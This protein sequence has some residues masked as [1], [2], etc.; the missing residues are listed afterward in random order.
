MNNR[1]IIIFRHGKSDWNASYDE[2]HNRP[3]SKK[4][5]NASKKMGMYLAD[6]KQVP[7][8]VIS[9][10]ATRAK[11]TATLAI[12][13]G[14]WSSHFLI[15]DRIYG[16]SSNFLLELIHLLDNSNKS[17]CF[18]GHEPTCSSFISLCTFHS[19]KFKTG[20]MAKIDYKKSTWNQ[21]KFGEGSL[22]WIK[23]PKEVA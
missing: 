23:A 10:S 18:V 6:I 5:I 17:V 1:S 7:D 11:S 22:G 15:D 12:K 4:G 9:S 14:N 8:I 19:Q 2:D 16:R 3:L 13:S 21:I 20:S